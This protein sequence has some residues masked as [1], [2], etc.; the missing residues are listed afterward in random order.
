MGSLCLNL[1]LLIMDWSGRDLSTLRASGAFAV[2]F[3][4]WK[5]FYYL[6]LFDSTAPLVR[7]LFQI[8]T[9]MTVFSAILFVS[10]LAFTNAFYILSLNR[11]RTDDD[12]TEEQFNMYD[13]S[14]ISAIVYTYKTGLGDF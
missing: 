7:M 4:W 9:D 6:R 13:Y 10:I 1:S 14:F 5:F 3:M 2:L 12:K 8:G 11:K